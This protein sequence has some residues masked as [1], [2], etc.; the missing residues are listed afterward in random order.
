MPHLRDR[1]AALEQEIQALHSIYSY[2]GG[3]D[4]K[5]A[6]SAPTVPIPNKKE[7]QIDYTYSR[8]RAGI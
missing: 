5:S 1:V 7:G 2:M 6:I 8:R 3:K 4:I